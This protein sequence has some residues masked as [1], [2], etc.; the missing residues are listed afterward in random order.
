MLLKLFLPQQL[1][2]DHADI[3]QNGYDY[4]DNEHVDQ[5]FG[6]VVT[7]TKIRVFCYS[8]ISSFGSPI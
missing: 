4:E 6:V 8:L 5:G 2:N 7:F 1:S 3:K